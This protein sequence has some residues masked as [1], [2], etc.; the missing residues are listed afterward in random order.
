MATTFIEAVPAPRT[1]PDINQLIESSLNLGFNSLFQ[2]E[3][4]NNHWLVTLDK[5]QDAGIMRLC[6]KGMLAMEELDPL[7]AIAEAHPA[8]ARHQDSYRDTNL[9]WSVIEVL[10]YS[11]L[12]EA[13]A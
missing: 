10:I 7:A 9:C 5:V 11:D 8:V 12:I 3:G 1:S 6:F 2:G 13:S 4:V